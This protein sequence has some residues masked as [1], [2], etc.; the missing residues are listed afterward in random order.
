MEKVDLEF[1]SEIKLAYARCYIGEF[2]PSGLVLAN[3]EDFNQFW[4]LIPIRKRFR[5]QDGLP[6]YLYMPISLDSRVRRFAF[7]FSDDYKNTV[8]SGDWKKYDV[9]GLPDNHPLK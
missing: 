9:E 6:V 4:N 3:E 8:R 7:Q 5:T 1:F 2:S